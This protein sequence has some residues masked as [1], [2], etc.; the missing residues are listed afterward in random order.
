M[1]VFVGR[2]VIL[3]INGEVFPLD[4]FIIQYL[5]IMDIGLA[6]Q[7]VWRFGHGIAYEQSDFLAGMRH[8]FGL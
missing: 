1:E 7:D 4:I 2:W 8:C 5:N 3:L 6:G